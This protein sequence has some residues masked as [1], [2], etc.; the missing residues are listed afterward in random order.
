MDEVAQPKVDPEILPLSK[1]WIRSVLIVMLLGFAGLIAITNLSYRN[2][3]P[4]PAL[5]VDSDGHAL[6][7]RAQI[8]SGQAVFLRYGLMDNGSV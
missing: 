6:F 8:G 1:W 7:T 4:I 3:P 2:A 5:V